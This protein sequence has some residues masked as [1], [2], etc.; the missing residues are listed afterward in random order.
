MTTLKELGDE[1]YYDKK[2]D[3][4]LQY[5]FSALKQPEK[6]I[7][8][9]EKNKYIIYSNIASAYIKKNNLQKSLDYIIKSIKDNMNW[10][11]TWK[12]LGYILELQKKSK[13]S[14]IAYK[15]SYD[16]LLSLNENYPKIKKELEYKIKKNEEGYMSEDTESET[17]LLDTTSENFRSNMFEKMIKNEKIVSKLNNEKLQKKILDNKFNPFIIFKDNELMELMNEMYSEFKRK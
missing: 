13:H 6:A 16:L 2:Y 12:K 5:Y 8:Q 1:A 10:F 3:V 9:P 14:L 17:E 15:R 11:K 7:K 4:A